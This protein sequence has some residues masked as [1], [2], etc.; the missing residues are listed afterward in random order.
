[1]LRLVAGCLLLA[2]GGV[3]YTIAPNWGSVTLLGLGCLPV[4]RVWHSR[5]RACAFRGQQAL[6]P[7][8]ADRVKSTGFGKRPTRTGVIL[9]SHPLAPIFCGLACHAR[10]RSSGSI[11]N[12]VRTRARPYL[13]SR[14]RTAGYRMVQRLPVCHRITGTDLSGYVWRDGRD[15]RAA[16]TVASR[17]EIS[18]EWGFSAPACRDVAVV[19]RVDVARALACVSGFIVFV[20]VYVVIVNKRRVLLWITWKFVYGSMRCGIDNPRERGRTG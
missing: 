9:C 17:S 6:N 16:F 4:L 11:R 12:A 2:A 13:R 8:V 1:M 20:Y 7:R 10:I 18:C 14:R 3:Y 5:S 15:D 19:V